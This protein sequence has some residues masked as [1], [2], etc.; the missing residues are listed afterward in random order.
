MEAVTPVSVMKIIWDILRYRFINL[1]IIR[2]YFY[3]IL[4]RNQLDFTESLG[5]AVH[6]TFWMC[7]FL[8]RYSMLSIINNKKMRKYLPIFLNINV[9]EQVFISMNEN[10]VL[11]SVHVQILTEVLCYNKIKAN[12][13]C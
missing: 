2:T 3:F 11:L 13:W 6:T 1:S 4:I 5:K 9:K 7:L 8:L 10:M 12:Q